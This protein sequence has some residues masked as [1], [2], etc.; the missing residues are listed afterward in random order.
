MNS[1]RPIQTGFTLIELL[2]VIAIIGILAGLVLPALA[3]S[4][5]KA[6]IADTESTFHQFEIML[7]EY[8]GDHGSYPPTYGYL[9]KNAR[10]LK[11][12]DLALLPPQERVKY[13]NRLPFMAYLDAVNTTDLYDNW[14]ESGDTN[15][16]G[17][18]DP[19][20]FSP[21]GR[22]SGVDSYDFYSAGV[23]GFEDTGGVGDEVERQFAAVQRPI[24]YIPVN[25]RQVK[26]LA[27]DL[28][29]FDNQDPRPRGSDGLN[30][31]LGMKFPPPTYDA[32]VLIS[33]GPEVNTH[34]LLYH[35]VPN[36][37]R[38]REQDPNGYYSYH[39]LGLFSYFMATRDADDN[40]QLDFEFRTR[41]RYNE[42]QNPNN[43]LPDN[44]ELGGPLI[45]VSQ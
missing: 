26:K 32:Y 19:L 43:K 3:R 1:A 7:T 42:G 13:F 34:G 10:G 20:E 31:I 2:V 24:I 35:T 11:P 41:T 14:S 36:P 12:T 30:R 38:N 16:D 9:L 17:Q 4:M 25:K 45:F 29:G 37:Y 18:I 5:E 28:Y 40:G 33:V 15:R 27:E 39:I 22:K 8:F 6:K 44:T 21:L 23:F